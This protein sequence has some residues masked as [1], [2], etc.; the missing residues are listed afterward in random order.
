MSEILLQK[1]FSSVQQ[2]LKHPYHLSERKNK[3]GSLSVLFF[4]KPVIRLLT[5]TKGMYI[6]L[7]QDYSEPPEVLPDYG[8]EFKAMSTGYM[9]FTLHHP[10]EIACLA[11]MINAAWEDAAKSVD[12]FGCCHDFL[13]C[14]DSLKCSYEEDPGEWGR[15]CWGCM[16][17]WNLLNGRIFYG[18]NAIGALK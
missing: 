10:E 8:L 4:E 13:R 12:S 11:P 15:R 17:H 16:Y 7:L 3:N 9:R 14:S 5:N 1:L 6:E 18:K 2:C